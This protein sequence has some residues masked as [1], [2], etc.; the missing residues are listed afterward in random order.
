MWTELEGIEREITLIDTAV[1][2]L[3]E[4]KRLIIQV[5]YLTEDGQDKG[6]K[7]TLQRH[8]KKY[9]W[10]VASHDTYEKLRN[11]AI[12]ELARILGEKKGE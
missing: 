5:R 10:R 4:P 1:G 6:A 3:S 11:E 8:G 9:N 2:M 12:T 7:I